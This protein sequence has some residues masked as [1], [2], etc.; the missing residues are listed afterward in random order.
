[1]RDPSYNDAFTLFCTTNDKRIWDLIFFENKDL[2]ASNERSVQCSLGALGIIR[3][4]D[5]IY[6]FNNALV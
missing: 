4:V 6:L 2:P 5:C 3:P 1:M